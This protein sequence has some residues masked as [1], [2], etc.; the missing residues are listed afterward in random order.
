M[1]E[2]YN[3]PPEHVPD[4]RSMH[5]L[6]FHL[7]FTSLDPTGDTERVVACGAKRVE[8]IRLPD[9]SHLVML[10]DPGGL[11]F[12]ICKRGRPLLA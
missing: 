7:A 3:N 9:G 11:A 12:Q 5:P 2:I 4:Y 6:L 8:E 1:L 10:R